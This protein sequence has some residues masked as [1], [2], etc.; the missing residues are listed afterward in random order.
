MKDSFFFHL[1]IVNTYSKMTM[2]EFLVSVVLNVINI[3]NYVIKIKINNDRLNCIPVQC[4]VKVN[5][6]EEKYTLD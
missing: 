1:T 2:F 5:L 6:K 3:L 4:I